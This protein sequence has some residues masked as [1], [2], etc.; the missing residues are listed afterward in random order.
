MTGNDERKLGRVA[1]IEVGSP[2]VNAI[3]SL[4]CVVTQQQQQQFI[5]ISQFS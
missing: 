2:A 1:E 5:H 4:S 3:N